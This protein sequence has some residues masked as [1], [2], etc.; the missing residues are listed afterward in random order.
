MQRAQI[1]REIE[2]MDPAIGTKDR[3][4]GAD[5]GNAWRIV[6]SDHPGGAMGCS[7]HAEGR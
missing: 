3:G 6:H 5:K 7:D 2:G 4:R 1:Y